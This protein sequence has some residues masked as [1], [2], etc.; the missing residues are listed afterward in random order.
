MAFFSISNISDNLA[1]FFGFYSPIV[2][3]WE[4]G[5]GGLIAWWSTHRKIEL[6]GSQSRAAHAFGL[7]LIGFSIATFSSETLVPGPSML[8]PVFGT[9]LLIIAGF[10]NPWSKDILRNVVVG[11]IGDWS[12]SI[13][14]WHW[15]MISI[16]TVLWPSQAFPIL[17]AIAFSLLLSVLSYYFVEST[18][19]DGNPKKIP[20]T[21]FLVAGII[22]VPIL[23]ASISLARANAIEERLGD[24]LA[25]FLIY[26]MGCHGPGPVTE[27]LSQCDLGA[28]N[29]ARPPT[30]YLF[31]DSSA[32]AFAPGMH[33]ASSNLG[34]S[35]SI[36]TAGGCP[37]LNGVS[38]VAPDYGRERIE[39]CLEW[40]DKALSHLEGVDPAIVV[41]VAAGIY[42]LNDWTAES[43][44]G[45]VATSPDKKSWLLRGGLNGAVDRITAAGHDLYILQPIP[46]L[47]T[48]QFWHLENCSFQ[49]T[50]VGCNQVFSSDELL[51]R[52][53]VAR[54][55]NALAAGRSGARVLD[56]TD[57]ICE[58]G[59][60]QTYKND[61]WVYRDSTH[62]TEGF[63]E[64]LAHRWQEVFSEPI[65]QNRF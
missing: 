55:S 21:K 49:L 10:G 19:R 13:Y 61:G 1:D 35:L 39:R 8:L 52:S 29:P 48:A 9:A 40:Q 57:A 59:I 44:S 65:N 26:E 63:A 20:S 36:A 18:M 31:G 25:S 33:K 47:A 45:A 5:I 28:E 2:R 14:L 53:A 12:Y 32:A 6:N 11:K 50:L 37:L 16:T 60:C 27:P 4:F 62:L 43:K 54:S 38:P 7:T 56:F 34:L 15:P 51:D 30:V 24:P 17:G 58:G 41:L 42:W 64:S 22:V 23:I 3:A 46:S